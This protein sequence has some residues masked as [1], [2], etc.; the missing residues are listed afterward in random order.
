MGLL[1]NEHGV[2]IVR[3]KVPERLQRAVAEA[4]GA[5]KPKQTFLQR[6]LRTKNLQQAKIAAKPLLIEFDQILATAEASLETRPVQATLSAAEIARMGEYLYGIM[7][8]SDDVFRRDAP[9]IER[10]ERELE[11]TE[12]EPGQV[13]PEYGLSGGQMLDGIENLPRIIREAEVAMA[14][15]D[16]SHVSH[17][18][19]DLLAL[20]RRNLDP[21]SAAYR[22]LGLALLRANV[23]ALRDIAKRHQGE[24]IDTPILPAIDGPSV[25]GSAETLRQAFEGWR[26]ARNPSRLTAVEF[27]RAVDLFVEQ[28]G[29]LP[30]VQIR[31]T[32]ARAFREALQSLPRHRSG[33][34]LHA[35]F[36]EQSA[37]GLANPKAQK[38]AASTINKLLGG[39]QAVALWSRDNGGIPDDAPWSD[40]FARM[41]LDEDEPSREPFTHVELARLFSAPVFTAGERQNG[42]RGEAAFWLPLI[43]LFTGARRGE[44][45]ALTCSD[46]Y[47]WDDS[48]TWV[49]DFVEDKERGKEL[50]TKGSARAVPLHPELV[51]LGLLQFVEHTRATKGKDAWLFPLIAG[52]RGK[53]GQKAWTKW[54]TRL[55]RTQGILGKNK[56]FHSFRHTFKDA[57]RASQVSE[58]LNDALT[59]HS[60]TSVGRSYGAKSVVQRFGI[61][62]LAKAV[63]K[64]RY[65]G[66][67]LS[68]VKAGKPTARRASSRSLRM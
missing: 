9:D 15:G 1:K 35:S 48:R 56:V 54:F 40:P 53:E 59:G 38:I 65:K 37:W 43:G 58:D 63:A 29:N 7:L 26:K 13:L 68:S 34:L 36:T 14:R 57:L 47:Q 24:P 61:H 10:E 30:V 41:R 66:L 64:V 16:I 25:G 6:S 45:A 31:K 55:L 62:G 8:A 27:Q 11:D 42:G 60:N 4:L 12:T 2:Y 44:I 49:F 21:R 50:K 17:R 46:V 32:H 51:R 5:A 52:E 28:H 18:L 23:R 22:D 3:K 19:S 20:F 39:V 67:D 33:Q